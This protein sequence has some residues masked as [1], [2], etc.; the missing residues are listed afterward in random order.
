MTDIAADPAANGVT[1]AIPRSGGRGSIKAW[2]SARP[3]REGWCRV[4]A[5][6]GCR[7]TRTSQCRD[8]AEEMTGTKPNARLLELDLYFARR[9]EIHR[10][11]RVAAPRDH[12]AGLECCARNKR[13]MSAMSLALKLSEQRHAGHHAPGYDEVTAINFVGESRGDDTDRQGDH[14]QSNEDGGGCN[15]TSHEGNQNELAIAD[16]TQRNDRPPHRVGNGAKFVGLRMAL[17][18]MHDARREQRSTYQDHE[19]AE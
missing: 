16:S 7:S 13:M 9:N 10:M 15:E 1:N 14:D 18:Q 4:I 12:D 6:G 5:D 11:R 19:A 8:L 17:G 2:R 3:A